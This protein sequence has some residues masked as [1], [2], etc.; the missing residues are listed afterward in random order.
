[1]YYYFKQHWR[2]H[3]IISLL[4]IFLTL[5]TQIG[6]LVLLCSLPLWRWVRLRHK[7]LRRSIK[8]SIL[9]GLYALVA[10]WLVPSLAPLTG[11]VALPCFATP[12]F[13]LQATNIGYC[14]LMRNYTTPELRNTI[15]HLS[16]QMAQ[17]YQG[18]V[19][20]YLDAN[21]PFLDG[22]PLLP[23]L[24]H[25][26]GE[27]L[28]LAFFY[29]D[30]TSQQLL[31]TTPSP[32]G[33]WAYEQPRSTEV[34]PCQHAYSLLR[35]DFAWLQ[36]LFATS[37]IDPMRTKVLL[38]HLVKTAEVKKILLEPHLKHRLG[39]NASKIRFQGCYAARHDDHI[40]L[41]L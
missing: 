19:V 27:K 22:F 24:S 33:Y 38:Q 21:F 31:N 4:F 14:L 39:L 6:G 9:F 3:F 7:V 30:K 17:T 2:W 20:N 5:L 11:R 35:W 25:D 37:E 10:T 26:D 34:Q 40:H 41:Q 12:A 36:P 23:H 13:P 18:T 28:D 16:Q 1:M 15:E 8:V 29:R 32:I